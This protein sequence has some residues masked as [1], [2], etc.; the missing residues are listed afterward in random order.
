[1]RC[2]LF[3]NHTNRD[4]QQFPRIRHDYDGPIN[5]PVFIIDRMAQR[6]PQV[7]QSMKIGSTA[8]GEFSSSIDE[9]GEPT[10]VNRLASRKVQPL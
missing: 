10:N 6:V 9:Q 1:M 5:R 4:E 8:T 3:P 2:G 7:S